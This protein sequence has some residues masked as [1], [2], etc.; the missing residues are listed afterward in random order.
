MDV[1]GE[2]L[3][4][5]LECPVCKEIPPDEVQMCYNGDCFCLACWRNLP[6]VAG[7]ALCTVC[8]DFLPPSNRCRAQEGHIAALAATCSHCALV[9]TRGVITE[10]E[11][12]FPQRPAVCLALQIGCSW[13]GWNADQPAHEAAC[14][15][16]VSQRVVKPLQLECAQLQC[17]VV[18]LE[19]TRASALARVVALEADADDM[20]RRA[21]IA[22]LRELQA[23]EVLR[24]RVRPRLEDPP[25]G[26]P[27]RTVVAQQ[28]CLRARKNEK[29]YPA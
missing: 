8:R 19:D 5:P 7:S 4:C 6:A 21:E 14:P 22:T 20:E 3:E 9:T 29:P 10:H 13:G 16:V 26:T 24:R 27:S 25:H 2:A 15:Y 17:R 11:R 12:S 23:A 28:M 1:V 18:E